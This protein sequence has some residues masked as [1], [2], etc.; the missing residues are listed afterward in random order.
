MSVGKIIGLGLIG[1]AAGGT[2]AAFGITPDLM[3]DTLKDQIASLDVAG[4]LGSSGIDV[5]TKDELAKLAADAVDKLHVIQHGDKVITVAKE[6]LTAIDVSGLSGDALKAAQAV[7]AH[8]L[9]PSTIATALKDFATV[10]PQNA[11]AVTE[12]LTNTKLLTAEAARELVDKALENG[13][14]L[15]EGALS[16]I[17]S[18]PFEQSLF[19]SNAVPAVGGATAGLGAGLLTSSGPQKPVIGPHTQKIWAQRQQ[20]LA[21]ALQQNGVQMS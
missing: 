21:S 4:N 9:E 17:G 16:T 20:Q 19:L 14:K 1:A 6:G 10:T 12:A 13:G 5:L 2:L 11:Q 3:T 15:A 7:N 18:T 8:F